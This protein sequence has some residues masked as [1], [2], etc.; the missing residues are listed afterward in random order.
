MGRVVSSNART[1]YPEDTY[2]SVVSMSIRYHCFTQTIIIIII[3]I[4]VITMKREI[5][6]SK[7]ESTESYLSGAQ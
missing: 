6:N 7:V 5:C 4:I 2:C 1:L 3:I